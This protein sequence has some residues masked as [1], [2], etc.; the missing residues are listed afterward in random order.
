MGLIKGDTRSLDY[1]SYR[2]FQKIGIPLE[3]QRGI[4]Y[5]RTC[6]G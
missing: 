2:D 4:R 3:G 1:S 6:R 5:M